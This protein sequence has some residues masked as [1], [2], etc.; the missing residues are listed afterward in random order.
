MSQGPELEV[1]TW[2][3]WSKLT[4]VVVGR[5]EGGFL[6]AYGGLA[7]IFP[8]PAHLDDIKMNCGEPVIAVEN[9]YHYPKK[10]IEGSMKEIDNLIR[11]LQ[12]H[13]INVRRPNAVDWSKQSFKQGSMIVSGGFGN[14]DPRDVFITIGNE[15]IECP[16]GMPCRHFEYESYE[17]IFDRKHNDEKYIYTIAPKPERKR[18]LY[19]GGYLGNSPFCLTE[20][21]PCF[22]AADSLQ[23]GAHIF[24]QRSTVTNHA[25]IEW[26]RQ[27]LKPKGIHVHNIDYVAGGQ[28]MHIDTTMA[29]I[30]PG[31]LVCN[32]SWPPESIFQNIFA[33]AGWRT[34][35]APT[36]TQPASVFSTAWLSMNWLQIDE[37]TIIIEE[38][39]KE[40]INLLET[41]G[42]K[43]I[44]IPYRHNYDMFGALHCS[45]LDLKREGKKD[46]WGF[47]A[48]YPSD[49]AAALN[50][51]DYNRWTRLS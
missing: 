23:F 15:V 44:P 47:K 40:M 30:E 51:Q 22:D 20:A 35:W 31:K 25:G 49:G 12:D 21:E 46:D 7:D 50:R 11:V 32:P 48:D 18:E 8:V 14:K 38:N 34:F 37:R 41:L 17:N 43:V 26:L 9:G 27:H 4:D 29:P 1:S 39:E 2:D 16:M 33:D 5:A 10:Q 45:T 6:P 13:N 36:P 24:M 42:K 3:E 19:A 28:Q